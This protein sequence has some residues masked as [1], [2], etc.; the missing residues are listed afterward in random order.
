MRLILK[1]LW[2]TCSWQMHGSALG[3]RWGVFSVHTVGVFRWVFERTMSRKSFAVGTGAMAF[4]P[5]VDI[6]GQDQ[7]L[8]SSSASG[9]LIEK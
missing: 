5:L 7:R 9:F 8:F 2:I 6:V 3:V 4:S 1:F